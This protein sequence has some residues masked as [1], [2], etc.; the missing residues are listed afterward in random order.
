MAAGLEHINVITGMGANRPVSESGQMR[1]R[2]V[3]VIAEA[4]FL[5][6]KNIVLHVFAKTSIK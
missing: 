4:A 3:S 5:Y 2:Q 6:K 1:M